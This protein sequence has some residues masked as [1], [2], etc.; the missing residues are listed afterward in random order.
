M[1]YQFNLDQAAQ[2]I[3]EEETAGGGETVWWADKPNPVSMI[4][5]RLSLT[6]I[7]FPIFFFAILIFIG[8]QFLEVFSSFSS[9]SFG[10]G[11]PAFFP[12]FFIAIFLFIAFTALKSFLSP[13]WDLIG[14][15]FTVYVITN[16]RA[17][18]IQRLPRRSVTSYLPKD[19]DNI[20]RIGNDQRG[21]VL[22]SSKTTTI[23][24]SNSIGFGNN[25]DQFGHNRS[26]GGFNI[27]IPLGSS[28]ARTR[29]TRGGF[30]GVSNPREVEDMLLSLAEAAD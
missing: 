30:F 6:Q 28:T 19:F 2:Q 16:Q 7:I 22:F 17:M 15:F 27:N 24:Q 18:V 25:N 5:S 29:T 4:R 11:M 26:G 14:S 13:L 23:Q 10:G 21:D 20:Q 8:R 1:N 3:I 12:Y 9:N